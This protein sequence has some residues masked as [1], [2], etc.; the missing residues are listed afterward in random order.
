MRPVTAMA[1]RHDVTRLLEQV[2]DGDEGAVG[3]LLARVYHEL[4]GIARAM[5]RSERRHHTLEPTAVVHEAFLRMTAGER[6]Q[7][8]NRAHFFGIAARAMRRVLVDHAR[9]RL[10]DKRGGAGRQQVEFEDGM[11][12]TEGQSEEVLAVNEALDQLE[13]LDPRQARI[14]EMHYFAGNTVAEI[15]VV[16]G[17]SERT[18]KR[19]LQTGRIFLKDRLRGHRARL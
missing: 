8:E 1:E 15:A 18:V 14:V 17:I 19:D 6:P 11:R 5:M 2:G 4:R 10:A 7:F 16:L 9:H 3:Q 12:L 13:E